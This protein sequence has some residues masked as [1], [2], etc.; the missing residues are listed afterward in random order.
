M[1]TS[2]RNNSWYRG[3]GSSQSTRTGQGKNFINPIKL[4]SLMPLQN[5]CFLEPR[6]VRV[7]LQFPASENLLHPLS[8]RV[9][10]V[11]CIFCLSTEPSRLQLIP[12]HTSFSRN[13]YQWTL[14]G[15]HFQSVPAR[16]SHCAQRKKLEKLEINDFMQ[17][18]GRQLYPHA[19]PHIFSNYIII[20]SRDERPFCHYVPP[21]P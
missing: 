6:K 1:S 16:I 11:L 8:A 15:G 9:D 18:A 7:I 12:M 14:L 5:N 19:V 21:S 3:C 10:F 2:V 20:A 4:Q 13:S 17:K